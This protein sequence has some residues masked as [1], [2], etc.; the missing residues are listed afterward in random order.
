MSPAK[1]ISTTVISL[2]LAAAQLLVV[3][4]TAFVTHSIS[5]SGEHH[6][7]LSAADQSHARHAGPTA[8]WCSEHVELKP[9]DDLA[10]TAAKCA[11]VIVSSVPAPSVAGDLVVPDH[12]ATAFRFT[13]NPLSVLSCSPKASPP[14]TRLS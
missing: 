14:S 9:V 4:H 12:H 5:S 10:C 6:H 1:P 3:T 8:T 13:R 7:V 11:T 2:L